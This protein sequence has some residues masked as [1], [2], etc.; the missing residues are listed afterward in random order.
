MKKTFL[1]VLTAALLASVASTQAQILISEINSNGTGGDFFE[2]Y[3][4]GSSAVDLGGWKWV[5]NA[6]VA[7]GSPSFNGARAYAFNAFTLN[8]GSS[9]LVVSDASGNA[10]GNTNFANSWGRLSGANFLTF[11]TTSTGNGL[12]QND[13]VAL[14]NST[15]SFVTGLNYGTSAVTITQGDTSTVSL[16]PFLRSGGG[17]SLGGHAGVA[18]GGVAT[19]SLVW[20][21]WGSTAEN[22]TYFSTSTVGFAG[23]FAN[24]TSSTTI[25]SPGVV[26]EPSSTALLGLGSLALLGLRRLNRKA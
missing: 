16:L 21:Y 13:L 8:A 10:T 2:I 20:N 11:T 17:N 19:D 24:A 12:G 5:D 3:N 25:G 18:G 22:P 4:A 26:P 23:A 1:A 6:S 14:F 9:A 15:G 7:N